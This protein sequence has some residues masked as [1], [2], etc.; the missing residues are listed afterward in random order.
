[1][2]SFDLNWLA[3]LVA[4]IVNMIIGAAWYGLL[5]EPWLE[6]IGKTREEIGESQSWKPYAVAV[7]NSAL[8][9]FMLANVMSWAG[10]TGLVAGLVTGLL[11][12]VGF[13]GFSFAANHAFEG[14][15]PRLWLINSGTY[16]LGLAVMGAIIG[17]W[18]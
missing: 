7:L 8:M 18:P 12:W 1:M 15:S 2:L 5:A 11:M 13:T 4:I 6:G 9:A 17:A 14:R 3:V 16:L 10:R